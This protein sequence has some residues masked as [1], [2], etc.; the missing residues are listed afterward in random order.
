MW[1]Y[2][3]AYIVLIG[4]ELNSEMEHQTL[5]DTTSGEKQPMGQRGAQKADTISEIP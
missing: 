4:A 5:K 1:L 2:L 3:S